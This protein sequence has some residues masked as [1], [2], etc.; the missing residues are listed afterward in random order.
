ML[1]PIARYKTQ[2]EEGKLEKALKLCQDYLNK[3]E[4]LGVRFPH[5]NYEIAGMAL[6]TCLWGLVRNR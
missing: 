3:M 1:A 5:R 4:A 6:C 2:F